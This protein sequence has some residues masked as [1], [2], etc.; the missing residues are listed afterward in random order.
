MGWVRI[1]YVVGGTEVEWKTRICCWLHTYKWEYKINFIITVLWHTW[2]I[3]CNWCAYGEKE[4]ERKSD[5]WYQYKKKKNIN[6]DK[7]GK[8]NDIFYLKTFYLL[9]YKIWTLLWLLWFFFYLF[10]I[11]EL[12]IVINFLLLLLFMNNVNYNLYHC[13]IIIIN[14]L[15]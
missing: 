5:R 10:K 7:V 13:I 14:F 3:T 11:F 4:R 9:F 2:K 6:N 8:E 12:Y 15:T 1:T